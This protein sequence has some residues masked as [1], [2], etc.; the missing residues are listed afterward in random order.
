MYIYCYVQ[1]FILLQLIMKIKTSKIVLTNKSSFQITCQV[2]IIIYIHTHNYVS[3]KCNENIS[4]FYNLIL[5]YLY[6]RKYLKID[7]Q[8]YIF[9]NSV[10]VC[11]NEIIMNRKTPLVRLFLSLQQGF[12][13]IKFL[14]RFESFLFRKSLVRSVHNFIL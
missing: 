4:T 14:E 2:R 8:D 7:H 6:L 5:I 10:I 1:S 9:I 11:Y 3:C 12:Q 13:I